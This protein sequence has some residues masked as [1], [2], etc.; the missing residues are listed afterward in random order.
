M[1]RGYILVAFLL[2]MTS[3]I[4]LT[5]CSK[6]PI[7]TEK[8]TLNVGIP[9]F[10]N[11][12]LDPS[13]EE[14]SVQAYYRHMYDSL[15]G[16]DANG[17]V[18]TS[19]SV[20][21][22]WS[23]SNTGLSLKIDLN[24]NLKWHDKQKIDS[25]EVAYSL[26]QHFRLNAACAA[27]GKF[28]NNIQDFIFPSDDKLEISFVEPDY[29]FLNTIGPA[30]EDIIL[31]K[32][33]SIEYDPADENKSVTTEPVGSGPWSFTKRDIGHEIVFDKNYDYWNDK[34]RANHDRLNLF[35]IPDYETRSAMLSSGQLDMA[36]I[37][38]T[39]INMLKQNGLGI[40]GPKYVVET[41]LRFCMSYDKDYLTSNKEFRK[42]LTLSLNVDNIIEEIYPNEM[43]TRANGSS[44]FTPIT[45][46]HLSDLPPY[47]YDPSSAKRSLDK[48][49]YQNEPVYLLS[50]PIYE[51]T[52]MLR[53]D[54]YYDRV[55]ERIVSDWQKN[56]INANLVPSNYGEVKTRYF[57]QESENFEDLKPAPIFH[58]GHIS[59]P[60]GIMNSLRRYITSLDQGGLQSYHS[61]QIG[62]NVYD[63]LHKF[64]NLDDRTKRL[65]EINREL[66]EEYWAV[67]IVWRHEVWGISTDVVTWNPANGTTSD[68]RFDTVISSN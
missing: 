66:Y 14:G 38:G 42:A 2:L 18:R 68:L 34:R 15:L 8:T 22:N 44:M 5:G 39:D 47:G 16:S 29:L 45:Q 7:N 54:E 49:G 60:G 10:G 53:Q 46:G 20:L 26:E 65:E 59:K 30:T 6:L 25:K 67:P 36:P 33:T 31:V 4:L 12:S 61:P 21:K 23:F 50:I 19:D 56:G 37:N 40:G 32:S 28:G 63:D 9:T 27:C 55:N 35:H 64:D 11:E 51:R 43:V 48:M 24:E 41:T 52:E 1:N 13:S 17:A 62:T 57:N 58:G 3:S